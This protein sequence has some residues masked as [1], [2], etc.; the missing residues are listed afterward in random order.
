MNQPLTP[1][2]PDS[3]N[4]IKK[5]FVNRENELR[6]GWRIGIFLLVFVIAAQLIGGL[7][8]V[9][10]I[11]F[12][13]LRL[14]LQ[15]YDL[16]ENG[17][18]IDVYRLGMINTVSLL[19]LLFANG[20]CARWLERRR[21]ASTGFQFHKGWWRDFAWGLGLGAI[22]LTIAVGIAAAA[23]A[24]H[25]TLKTADAASLAQFFALF[26]LFFLLAAANEEIMVRGFAFQALDHNLGSVAALTITSLIFGLL[27]LGNA[28]VTIFSTFN[29]ILAGLWLGVAYLMT[30]SLWLATALHFSWNFVMAFVFGLPVSGI[31]VF[32]N[33]AWL[34]GQSISQ[35]ISGTDYGPEGG[36]AATL[37]LLLCTLF[38]WKIGPFHAT[39]EMVAA[40]RHGRRD[41]RPL[42][43]T[44]QSFEEDKAKHP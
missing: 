16:S 44:A 8:V 35:W 22:T 3:A 7:I 31:K 10:S 9:C 15:P 32:K 42:S 19:A 1:Q 40:V 5:I 26:V 37:A 30:R 6:S 11:L 38:I 27:H 28:D 39:P 18:L 21:F 25:F 34:D 17:A 13:A 2:N 29:T 41:D 12:P 4:S 23:G 24:S 33:F 20:V 43:I 36:A 14:L